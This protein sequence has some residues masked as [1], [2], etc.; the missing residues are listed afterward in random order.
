M[1]AATL[2]GLALLCG[3]EG[4]GW[5]G[6]WPAATGEDIVA[7]T[8]YYVP[9]MW[10]HDADRRVM[11]FRTRVYLVSARTGKGVFVKGPITVAMNRLRPRESGGFDREFLYEWDLDEQAAEGFR[12]TKTSKIGD[13]YGFVLRW[14][15]EVNPMGRRIE[16]TFQYQRADGRVIR[17]TPR[18]FIVPVPAGYPMPS[19][20]EL[21]PE[22]W[23]AT[24]RPSPATQRG[25]RP[26]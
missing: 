2:A 15:T 7:I 4:A 26:P 21:V 9:L 1:R 10:L 5:M 6:P 11:G 12:V 8:P 14:P 19:E 25:T 20:R 17:A 23:E 18:Q 24:S 13:S 3:C 22:R 16:M